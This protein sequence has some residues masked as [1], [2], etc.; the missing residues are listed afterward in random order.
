M[1]HTGIRQMQSRIPKLFR[2]TL[3]F[4]FVLFATGCAGAK[5]KDARQAFHRGNVREAAEIIHKADSS[6]FSKLEYLMEKGLLLY[7]SGEYENS[8]REFRQAADLIRE[9][10]VISVSQQASSLVI[11][12]WVTEYKGEY[13]E[14]LWVHTYLMMNYLLLMKNEDAL[15]EAKQ[16][17][18][19]LDEF[20]DALSGA[21]FT[22]ALIAL[23]YEGLDEYNDAYI[24]YKNLA[25]AMPNPSLVQPH[26]KRL[27]RILGF[28]DELE[29]EDGAGKEQD[30]MSFANGSLAELI[31]FI[32]IGNGPQKISGNILLPPGIRISFPRY[33]KQRNNTDSPKVF[34][35]RTR[36]ASNQIETDIVAVANDS[37]DERAKQIY[38]KE[39]ARIAAKEL[40]VRGFERNNKDSM[41]GLLIRLA[42]IAMEEADTRGWHTLP[43]KL[44]LVRVYLEPGTHKIKV[45]I[46]EGGAANFIDLPEITFSPGEKVFY[47]LRASGGSTSANE[48]RE[49]LLNNDGDQA[50]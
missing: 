28:Q 16:A 11:N 10:D 18:Q 46:R 6:G 5:L 2:I 29:P 7:Q 21:Y 41:A 22:R 25:K 24:V 3:L 36:K 50:E 13:S 20:P 9:L 45:D 30:G 12:E 39:A 8:I 48:M 26:I 44:S 1:L 42:F 4:L 23:C 14:R 32:S 49:E 43:A 27:G 15:V 31:M 35:F 37:L 38:A 40:I 47:S 17:Q 33:K 34:D 19:F